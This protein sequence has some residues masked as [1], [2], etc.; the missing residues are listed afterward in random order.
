MARGKA[1][2]FFY[3]HAGYSY[4]PKT[5][6]PEQGRR[7][8]AKELAKAEEWAKGHGYYF[9]WEQEGEPWSTFLDGTEVDIDDVSDIVWVVMRDDEGKVVQSLG[10]I[11][12][13]HDERANRRYRRVVEA[14]LALEAM[15]PGGYTA[16]AAPPTM[17]ADLAMINKH[18][19][20][21]GQRPLDPAAAGWQPEDVAAEARRI[22]ALNPRRGIS[23]RQVVGSVLLAGVG[24]AGIVLGR[25][26]R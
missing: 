18:R 25:K 11:I 3:E 1:E 12:E 15:A 9:E 14:E 10:G 22:R 20:R 24:V 8:G 5:E 6:T 13:G 26:N 17:A 16:P 23:V 7:R 19:A 21:L 4:D 2:D